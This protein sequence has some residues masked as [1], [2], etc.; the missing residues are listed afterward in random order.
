VSD[1]QK[2]KAP[3]ARDCQPG[4]KETR[5]MDYTTAEPKA[6]G[7]ARDKA[8]AWA[9]RAGELAE[10]AWGRMVNRAD[11]WGRYGDAGTY[12]APR[13]SLRGLVYLTEADVARHF[14]AAG[15]DDILG[16]HTTSPD[17]LS[18]WSAVDIDQ[19]GPGGNDP[20]A[21][22][23]AA[24]AW[25]QR[26]RALGFCPI[27]TTSNGAGGS[28]LRVI[29]HEPVPTPRAF[30][31]ARWLVRDHA[32]PGLPAPPETF[33]KQPEIK[34]GGCGNWL[35]LP[36]RHHKRDHWSQVWGGG[37]WLDGAAAVAW[38]L[39]VE[40]DSPGLIPRE[41]EQR[42][43]TAR[44]PR[45]YFRPRPSG[46]LSDRV[47]AYLRRLPNLGEGQGRD[48]IGYRFACF[49]V[50][51]LALGDEAAREWLRR[52]DAGNRPPKGEAEVAKWIASARQ[53]G[54]RPVGCGRDREPETATGRLSV[55]PGRRPG[56][57]TLR[58]RVE[59]Y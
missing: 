30:A 31:F 26:A 5:E 12:T 46:N 7:T 55:A 36:G 48:D 32:R 50:R 28:H 41:A 25:H 53:Y 14:R 57:S 16:V 21:N 33:P 11:V 58:C 1:E 22:L 13:K 29:F 39:S 54:Q 6:N 2:E 17:N 15:R 23:A 18:R 38:L 43:E 52:W 10:W 24:L 27:L 35:R 45:P 3:A 59:V 40:G 20:A 8:A 37:R 49:L 42:P 34:P 56:H 4:P 44:G 9:I 47:A 19:H 51:D